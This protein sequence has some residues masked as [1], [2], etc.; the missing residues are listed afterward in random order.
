MLSNLHV[1][2]L[3]LMK[4]CDMN[5]RPGLNILTGETG[6]GKSLL[7]GSVNL[8]LGGKA[9]REMIRR[10]CDYALVE[11]VFENLGPEVYE[12]LQD[13]GLSVDDDV[14]ILQR[15]I[16]ASRST[17]RINGE[18]VTARQ[19]K[20]LAE[21]LID[22]HGQ[23]EH[24]SLLKASRQL[25]ILDSYA[26][27]EQKEN[28]ER[29]KTHYEE[30]RQ[31]KQ[32]LSE[33][34][35]DESAL[36]RERDLLNYEVREITAA[37]L[38]VGED[39]ELEARFLKLQ[40][41][42]RIIEALRSCAAATGYDEGAGAL[43]SRALGEFRQVADYD[44][45]LQQLHS[46][47]LDIDSLLSDFSR[48]ALR[49][50][51]SLDFEEESFY[52]VSSRLT[53]VNRL[54][55]KYGGSVQ[56]ALQYC[57]EKEARLKELEHYDEYIEELRQK[58]RAAYERVIADCTEVTAVRRQCAPVLADTLKTALSELNFLDVQFSIALRER[59]KPGEKGME[60]A[61]FLISLNP[62]EPLKPMSQ[63]ASGG[64]LSRIMLAIKTVLA[65]QDHIDTLIFDEIDSGISGNTAWRVSEKLGKL[66]A[67][68]QVIC[69]THLPQ[70]AAMADA[71]YLISKHV[72]EGNTVSGIEELD[73]EA[74]IGELARM[75]GAEQVTDSA[76]AH[77]K[78]M[79]AQARL[80]K[81]NIF[82]L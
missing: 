40:N 6:A 59:E 11:L 42:R 7:M 17:I 28:L 75:L 10:G 22:I 56:S 61:E 2:N 65:D 39:E 48:E 20:E 73:K 24:Q 57:Q 71:H 14:V 25:E 70:I 34:D 32:K 77:A 46:S 43:V 12:K 35:L 26:G 51:D 78:D 36:A 67:S 21:L 18:Q 82:T 60:D 49:Y 27:Q 30:Y 29:L 47:L 33:E 23:H 74:S 1:K 4:E 3:A 31:A 45:E 50:A 81:N 16:Q 8:A 44:K 72:E 52:E 5:L 54:K 76:A 13:M 19:V 58:E 63:V 68:H 38:S 66:A 15:K 69:I 64:E 37:A 80:Y 53:E 62:G 9:D 79:L 41:A 55:N